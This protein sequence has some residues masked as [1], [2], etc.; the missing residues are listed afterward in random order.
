MSILRADSFHLQNA[1][2]NVQIALWEGDLDPGLAE[3]LLNGKIQIAVIAARSITHF[4]T[5]Y[6]QL[7]VDRVVAES[8]EKNAWRRVLPC[9]RISA[10]H[11]QQ[12]LSHLVQV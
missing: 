2:A 7:E 4:A 12:R 5:P 11:R 6:H 1:A 9:L 8:A 10:V 3:F